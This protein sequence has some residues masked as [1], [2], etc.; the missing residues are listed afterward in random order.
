MFVRI[1][2]ADKI[3]QLKTIV[4]VG[5]FSPLHHIWSTP[6]MDCLASHEILPTVCL[7]EKL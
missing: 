6:G 3:T 5:L 2:M 1:L 4:S 7:A